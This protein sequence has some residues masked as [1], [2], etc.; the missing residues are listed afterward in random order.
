MIGIFDSGS[1]GLTVLKEIRNKAPNLDTL[2][3]GDHRHM[4]YGSRS[5]EELGALTMHAF[6]VLESHGVSQIVSACNSVSD[7]VLTFCSDAIAKEKLQVIEMT[8]PTVA[9]MTKK[10]NILLIATPATVLSQIYEKAFN[11]KDIGIES[12]AMPN[13]AFAIEQNNEVGIRGAIK[14]AI[15]DIK[16]INPETVLLGCTQF[17]LAKEIFEEMFK[18]YEIEAEICDPGCFV[19]DEVV[20]QFG[21]DGGG[22]MK[23]FVSQHTEYFESLVRELFG[24]EPTI[25]QV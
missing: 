7:S 23:F 5:R 22:S 19:A 2:Y 11:E 20:K 14:V 16:K 13:L 8:K 24:N 25:E 10:R 21:G 4:P 18:E 1:G 17:P 12:L 6:S 3:F 15:Q 9:G